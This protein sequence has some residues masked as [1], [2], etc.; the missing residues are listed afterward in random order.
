MCDPALVDAGANLPETC[1]LND[2]AVVECDAG[3]DT[4]PWSCATPEDGGVVTCDA[5]STMILT[6][7][8]CQLNADNQIHCVNPAAKEEETDGGSGTVDN[9][10][11]TTADDGATSVTTFAAALVAAVYALVF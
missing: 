3:F 5:D 4:S 2:D 11:D 6:V 9:T 8:H 7:A 1:R 10:T